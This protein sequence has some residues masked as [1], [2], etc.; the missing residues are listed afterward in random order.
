MEIKT[1]DYN[2][3]GTSAGNCV[4]F[5]A[6]NNEGDCVGFGDFCIGRG[7]LAGYL[8]KLFIWEPYRGQGWG[9]KL[10]ACIEGS[11]RE[12]GFDSLTI[13]VPTENYQRVRGFCEKMGMVVCLTSEDSYLFTKRLRSAETPRGED[14]LIL[15]CNILREAGYGDLAAD[16]V[17]AD[18]KQWNGSHANMESDCE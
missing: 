17:R 4:L 2:V 7:S 9:R 15:A 1:L 8:S 5:T 18:H 16:V 3:T 11:A 6:Y 14:A 12:W 13:F 10:F